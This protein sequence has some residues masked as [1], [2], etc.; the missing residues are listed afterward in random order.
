MGD[1]NGTEPMEGE[2]RRWE[3]AGEGVVVEKEG[4][5]VDKSGEVGNGS[6][7]RVVLQTQDSELV[8]AG[9]CVGSENA[10]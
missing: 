8:K 7:E 9:Q 4:F 1:I 2:E 6:G 5:E 3:R 10:S